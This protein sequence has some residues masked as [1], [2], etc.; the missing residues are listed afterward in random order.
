MRGIGR[1][2]R[3]LRTARHRLFPGTLVLLYHRVTDLSSD[4]FNLCVTPR[5]FAEHLEVLRAIAQPIP[6]KT[7]TRSIRSGKVPRKGVVVTFDDGYADNLLTALPLLEKHDIPATFFIASG[8]I[9]SGR[10]FWWDELERVVFHPGA[11]LSKADFPSDGMATEAA[12]HF[13]E[14]R[15]DDRRRHFNWK[16]S[17]ADS[18]HPRHRL[19]RY[20]YPRLQSMRPEERDSIIRRIGERVGAEPQV[21]PEYRVMTG[22][23]LC[24]MAGGRLVEIGAH[25]VHHPLLPALD[26][27]TQLGE[28]LGSKDSLECALGRRIETFS[29]PHGGFTAETISLTRDVGFEVALGT[30]AA[31]VSTGDDPFSIPRVIPEG[32][33]G[34]AFARFLRGWFSGAS[35]RP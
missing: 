9:G 8:Y 18:P 6:L 3:A 13:Q 34:D 16:Y 23:D 27:P 19:Y 15:E 10:E 31:T 5:A 14:F 12:A 24:R 32:G 17:D 1:I 25:T 33:D 26:G 29:Y 2:K 28:I 11:G 21:R 30:R 7:L 20:L 22:E 4:P 35:R